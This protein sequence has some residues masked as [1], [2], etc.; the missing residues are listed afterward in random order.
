MRIDAGDFAAASI[1]GRNDW[2]F[3]PVLC[4]FNE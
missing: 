4:V 1:F 3:N 2:A